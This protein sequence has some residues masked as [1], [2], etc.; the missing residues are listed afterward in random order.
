MRSPRDP[1]LSRNQIPWPARISHNRN[2]GLSEANGQGDSD[3]TKMPEWRRDPGKS[4]LAPQREFPRV[5]RWQGRRRQPR[6]AD[7]RN[8]QGPYPQPPIPLDR[9]PLER[10]LLIASFSFPPTP[11]SPYR[12]V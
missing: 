5:I 10:F 11:L 4:E 6:F 1:D 8:T 9:H 3:K 7:S 12:L 2:R